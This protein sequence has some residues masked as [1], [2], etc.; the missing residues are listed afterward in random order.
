MKNSCC[1]VK[2]GYKQFA[3]KYKF[4]LAFEDSICKDFVTEKF[5]AMFNGNL[6][7]VPVVYGG[8]NYSAIA[9]PNSFIDASKFGSPKALAHHLKVYKIN[10]T[11]TSFTSLI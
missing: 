6:D 11:L 5:F 4:F 10:T 9:P 3:T 7:M 8:G 1:N 2:S